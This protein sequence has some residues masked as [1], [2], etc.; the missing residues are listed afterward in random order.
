MRSI[1]SD[2]TIEIVIPVFNEGAGL[3]RSITTLHDFLRDSRN[4]PYDWRIVIADNASTDG[5]L[6][7]AH[8]LSAELDRTHVLHLD[9]KGRGRALKAA[10]AQSPA[11]IVAYMD[12][13]LSTGLNGLLPLISPIASGHS[14]LAIGTRLA[15]GAR[16]TRGPKREFISRSYNAIL[17]T[18]LRARFSD[19]QCGFKAIRAD[20]A[21]ELL[22]A[23]A[24]Q[25]WF[26]DT[27]LLMLAQRR[28]LR[29]AEIPVDWVDDPDSR[30]DILATA[31][32]DLRGVARILFSSESAPA[33]DP[34]PATT[35]GTTVPPAAQA[36]S[37]WVAKVA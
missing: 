6:A 12:V 13:D 29:I 25:A 32:A 15:H 4:M 5:T 35:T 16:V 8:E 1:S 23:V 3:A 24:D 19:A 2:P 34:S 36:A 28:G 37:P 21:R 11:Q 22:P 30:V 9:E 14:E 33:L 17:R 18:L 31:A 26:F 7:L 20:V 10:W 27:E